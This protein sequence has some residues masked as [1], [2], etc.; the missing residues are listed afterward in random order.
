V[1]GVNISFS[2]FCYNNVEFL[3]L[4]NVLFTISHKFHRDVDFNKKSTMYCNIYAC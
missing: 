4:V 2:S 1:D 3:P